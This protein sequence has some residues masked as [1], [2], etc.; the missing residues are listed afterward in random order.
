VSAHGRSKALTP[1]RGQRGGCVRSAPTF[2]TGR[3][4]INPW[5]CDQWGHLNAQ[6]YLA[7]ASEAQAH[8]AARL[9]LPPSKLRPSGPGLV[10]VADRALFK[11]ELRAGQI[12]FIRTGIRA[13][14]AV[15]SIDIASRM[16]NQETGIESAAFETRLRWVAQDRT[17]PLPWPDDVFAL[18]HANAGALPEL[19][20][21]QPMAPVLP[22]GQPDFDR[23]L[24]TY[25]G[26]VEAWE[27]GPD[28]LAPPRAQIARFNDA[29]THLYRAMKIDRAELFASGLGSAA[30][31]YDITYH[32]TIRSGQAVDV[33]SRVLAVGD[34]VFHLV[35]H[36]LDTASGEVRTTIVVAALFFDL[37]ARKAVPIPANIRAEAQRLLAGA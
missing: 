16:I 24:L 19:A 26:S 8:L 34:K 2:I 14:S 32:R 9:G 37:A 21:P 15:G 13:V 31:D 1:E 33:R 17:Q 11:R 3:G 27:C 5:E 12:Y 30:L 23:L 10:P 4:A 20:M 36:V 18:A 6:F 7:K 35:H 29:I 22:P 25:R 28:G